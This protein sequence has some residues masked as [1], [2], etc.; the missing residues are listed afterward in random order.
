[1]VPIDVFEVWGQVTVVAVNE[2]LVLRL[3]VRTMEL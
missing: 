3:I 2:Q 1:M